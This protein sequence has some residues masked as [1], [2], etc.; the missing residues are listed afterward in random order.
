[1]KAAVFIANGFE[2]LETFSPIDVLKRCGAEIITVS[3]N[4]DLFVESSQKDIFKVNE[5]IDNLDYENLDL[6]ILPGGYPGYINLRENKKVINILKFFLEKNKIIAAIC[7]APTIFSYNKLALGSTLTAHSST[8]SSFLEDYNFVEKNICV[9][10]NIIT[11][12]GAG[13]SL[14]FAFKI[15]EKFFSIEKIN[16]VKKAMELKN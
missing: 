7:G 6:I 13:H 5:I 16:E 11:A 12:V 2:V 4:S 9:D 14:E 8:K 15:A 1:M 10:D 3:I